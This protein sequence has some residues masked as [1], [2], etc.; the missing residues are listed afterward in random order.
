[1]RGEEEEDE[2]TRKEHDMQTYCIDDH[3]DPRASKLLNFLMILCVLKFKL[4][5]TILRAFSIQ[6]MMPDRSFDGPV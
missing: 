6:N 4:K 5:K 1:M 3:L 2:D